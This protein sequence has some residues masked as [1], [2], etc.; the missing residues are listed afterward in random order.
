MTSVFNFS[1]F[2]QTLLLVLCKDL[3]FWL[4]FRRVDWI[5]HWLPGKP[6]PDRQSEGVKTPAILFDSPVPVSRAT[7]L[8]M[9]TVHT[10][11]S[12]TLLS[13]G[14]T[15][16][17]IHQWVRELVCKIF[18][19]EIWKNLNVFIIAVKISNNFVFYVKVYTV[20][21][22]TSGRKLYLIF[23]WQKLAIYYHNW[24]LSKLCDAAFSAN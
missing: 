17:R 13:V 12:L 20:H 18:G 24:R 14:Y 8:A 23:L 10:P 9:F 4:V 15:W 7:P 5:Q 11:G 19:L 16:G 3:D 6:S 21:K 1:F 22:N 2:G